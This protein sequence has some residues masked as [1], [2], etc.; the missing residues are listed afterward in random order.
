MGYCYLDSAI[1]AEH[2]NLD[3]AQVGL[4]VDWC[5]VESSL[6]ECFDQIIRMAFEDELMELLSSVTATVVV[7]EPYSSPS[8]SFVRHEY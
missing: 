5:L 6:A 4:L 7:L 8:S 3:F 2:W 1:D